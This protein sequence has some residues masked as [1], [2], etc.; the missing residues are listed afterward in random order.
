MTGD[1][2]VKV[3]LVQ[4][5]FHKQLGVCTDPWVFPLDYFPEGNRQALLPYAAHYNHNLGSPFVSKGHCSL[6]SFSNNP[7]DTKYH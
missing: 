5:D 4:K 1:V 6:F 7:Q 3:P 2:E